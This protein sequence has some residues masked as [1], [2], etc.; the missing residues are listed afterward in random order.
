MPG[1]VRIV[2]TAVPNERLEIGDI[3]VVHVYA[4]GREITP[5]RELRVS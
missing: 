2:L 3:A 5:S 1:A 4:M